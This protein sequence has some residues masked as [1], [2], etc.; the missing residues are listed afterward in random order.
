MFTTHYSVF[1]HAG[2]FYKG[3]KWVMT[4]HPGV[5]IWAEHAS[6]ASAAGHAERV[7]RS[8]I[9]WKTRPTVR[10]LGVMVFARLLIAARPKTNNYITLELSPDIDN[11]G[12]LICN[13][14]FFKQFPEFKEQQMEKGAVQN[15]P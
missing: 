8:L 10:Q 5:P 4:N 12:G 7:R 15:N 1:L 2:N 11:S 14:L 9:S 3:A 13:F 6:N